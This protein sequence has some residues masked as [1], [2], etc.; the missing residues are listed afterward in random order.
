MKQGG[1]E[2]CG[3]KTRLLE[4]FLMKDESDARLEKQQSF[5]YATVDRFKLIL[6]EVHFRYNDSRIIAS[7]IN[8][9]LLLSWWFSNFEQIG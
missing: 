4:W 5:Y 7:L 3:S 2:S 1:A 9:T 8:K 6:H